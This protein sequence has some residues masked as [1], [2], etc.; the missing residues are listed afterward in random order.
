MGSNYQGGTLLLQHQPAFLPAIELL[1]FYATS[2]S[3][4]QSQEFALSFV[5]LLLSR[6]VFLSE[7]NQR[8][9]LEILLTDGKGK[10]HFL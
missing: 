5:W 1:G 7:L 10:N 6:E 8:S 4:A 9:V 3:A 2:L